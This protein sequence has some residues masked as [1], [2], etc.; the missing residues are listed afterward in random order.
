MEDGGEIKVGVGAP[1]DASRNST[2][3]LRVLEVATLRRY[4][5]DFACFFTD[6]LGKLHA[7]SVC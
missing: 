4:T 7:G 5:T 1:R 6:L 2:A 3:H